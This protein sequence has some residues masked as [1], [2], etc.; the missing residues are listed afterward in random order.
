M[1]SNHESF[2]MKVYNLN[3]SHVLKLN[4]KKLFIVVVIILPLLNGNNSFELVLRWT[5]ENWRRSVSYIIL[6]ILISLNWRRFHT[7]L[8]KIL[9]KKNHCNNN[10]KWIG[11]MH[12]AQPLYC[13]PIWHLSW[14]GVMRLIIQDK[15]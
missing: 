4:V 7:I 3:K 14:E 8:K 9:P 11:W 12:L 6:L 5:R 13:H 1:K 10:T 2:I 15:N